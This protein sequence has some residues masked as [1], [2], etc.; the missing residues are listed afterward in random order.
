MY[1][2]K[3]R[4]RGTGNGPTGTDIARAGRA[5]D[6]PLQVGDTVS[7]VFDNPEERAF[8]RGYSI[9][10]NT[11]AAN[12]CYADDN[13]TTPA[14]D[15]G[16]VGRAWQLQMFDYNTYGNW[17]WTTYGGNPSDD[18]PLF[19]YHTAETGGRLDF[20][21]TSA[22]TFDWTLTP[23]A[24]PELAV[25]QSGTVDSTDPIVWIEF[26]MFNSDSDFYPGMIGSPAATDF[27]I[28][29]IEINSEA[30][31]GLPG[32]FNQDGKVDAA[33]YV[34]WRKNTANN[35]L[36]NDDGLTTQAD[37]Y[38]LWRG[39]FGDMAGSGGG[40]GAVPE[41]DTFVYIVFAAAGLFLWGV[42]RP[43][44]IYQPC[45]VKKSDKQSRPRRQNGE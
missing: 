11:T 24:N 38:N 4:P 23:L 28:R 3:G 16:S 25:T 17:Q 22:T 1:N 39:N 40:A 18:Y 7:I 29:S 19:D 45:V 43:N 33:D 26:Q 35:P 8:F 6:S 34:T 42:R 12:G 2:P 5:L 21:L 15:P 31:P 36:P 20:T 37:R 30:P 9:I 13:C 32:D 14:Y 10:F 44:L 27:Y 41:P